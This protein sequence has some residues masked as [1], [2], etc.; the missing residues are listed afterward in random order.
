M[1]V[2]S[3]AFDGHDMLPSHENGPRTNIGSS[4]FFS[5]TVD[6]HFATASYDSSRGPSM[7]AGSLGA[8]EALEPLAGDFEV[9]AL[10][11]V[12]RAF[13]GEAAARGRVLE[14]GPGDPQ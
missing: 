4:G 5:E 7:K 13:A 11:G 3:V 9:V 8:F 1:G 6:G 12:E 10:A 2:L 14:A